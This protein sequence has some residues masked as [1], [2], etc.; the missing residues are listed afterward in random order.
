MAKQG[1]S[2]RCSAMAATTSQMSVRSVFKALRSETPQTRVKKKT[3]KERQN[4]VCVVT[5]RLRL[6]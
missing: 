5:P 3:E 1:H 4:D 6:C 2:M